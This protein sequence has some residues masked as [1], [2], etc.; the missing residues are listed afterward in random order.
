MGIES[1]T[2]PTQKAG[3]GAGVTAAGTGTGATIKLEPGLMVSSKPIQYGK[4]WTQL[5]TLLDPSK[6]F[7]GNLKKWQK[8]VLKKNNSYLDSNG[9][10]FFIAV[11]QALFKL[12]P[13]PN[14]IHQND[15]NIEEHTIKT[16]ENLIHILKTIFTT[17]QS[18]K[19]KKEPLGLNMLKKVYEDIN[20]KLPP[21]TLLD[22][23]ST[24]STLNKSQL[25][26]N[27]HVY[28]MA[29]RID[30]SMPTTDSV[31]I[32]SNQN[33]DLL[34]DLQL[35]IISNLGCEIVSK[36]KPFQVNHLEVVEIKN[37]NIKILNVNSGKH[38]EI[39]KNV[40]LNKLEK[41]HILYQV[42]KT[43]ANFQ[44]KKRRILD[45]SSRSKRITG[46]NAGTSAPPHA[47]NPISKP[48][49]VPKKEKIN[50]VRLALNNINGKK[51]QQPD[52]KIA[53]ETII[54]LLNEPKSDNKEDTLTA[55][56]NLFGDILE[57]INKIK[58]TG[59]IPTLKVLLPNLEKLKGLQEKYDLTPD[60]LYLLISKN[61]TEKTINWVL[62]YSDRVEILC[63]Y[64]KH[65]GK[66]FVTILANPSNEKILDWCF[67]PAP[68]TNLDDTTPKTNFDHLKTKLGT[69]TLFK[70]MTSKHFTYTQ[71]Q[72]YLKIEQLTGI[73]DHTWFKKLCAH[74]VPKK[75]KVKKERKRNKKQ[76]TTASIQPVRQLLTLLFLKK[77]RIIQ[78]IKNT[79]LTQKKLQ[80]LKKISIKEKIDL[81]QSQSKLLD[82]QNETLLEIEEIRNVIKREFSSE[83]IFLDP[84]LLDELRK[85]SDLDK[86]LSF[87][88][89][90]ISPP[91]VPLIDITA[92]ETA[93]IK[94]ATY[95]DLRRLIDCNYGRGE[96]LKQ[97]WVA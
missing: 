84:I 10:C 20:S 27:D 32:D 40:F 45:T 86:I 49:D 24:L 36:N 22:L 63:D 25:T 53:I 82:E 75:D 46:S 57:L 29:N 76:K 74:K 4:I 67:E 72:D 90:P 78:I 2:I 52:T 35:Q 96:L 60:Q 64:F 56:E 80:S 55:F 92:L 61:G 51:Y 13:N 97:I 38:R 33:D 37:G 48:S 5:Q 6:E 62:K 39:S 3:T 9:D 58:K 23:E 41:R 79:Q 19:T 87:R 73:P 50:R 69:D 8:D 11:T 28:L 17:I 1:C 7:V 31:L 91:P 26:K 59:P 81:L 30:S 66:D 44:P 70:F 89:P 47:F 54:E 21:N 14:D 16:L 12:L 85:N 68:N 34:F 15:P 94:S 77:G 95:P 65:N 93:K 88:F 18:K 42:T 83:A 43:D 71:L